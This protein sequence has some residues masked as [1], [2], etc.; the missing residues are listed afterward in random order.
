MKVRLPRLPEPVAR[1]LTDQL[2]RDGAWV[3][4]DDGE[5]HDPSRGLALQV[6]VTALDVA[7]VITAG[8]GVAFE[9]ARRVRDGGPLLL[10]DDEHTVFRL[11]WAADLARALVAAAHRQSEGRYGL[12]GR[13]IWTL[14]SLAQAFAATLGRHVEIL[15]APAHVLASAGAVPDAPNGEVPPLLPDFEPTPYA[16]WLPAVLDAAA[17]RPAPDTRPRELALAA[18]LRR[19]CS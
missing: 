9:V 12:A 2:R 16:R 19:R 7:P 10:P 17:S 13:E 15:R 1:V 8:E 3:S 4:Y 11:T 5:L 14:E 6:G 18:R